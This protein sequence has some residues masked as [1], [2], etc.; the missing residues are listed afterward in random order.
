MADG[1]VSLQSKF[2]MKLFSV[3]LRLMG[4]KKK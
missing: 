4:E 3:S 1:N 2:S